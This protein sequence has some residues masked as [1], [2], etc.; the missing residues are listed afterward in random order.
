M[1]VFDLV[2]YQPPANLEVALMK[3]SAAERTLVQECMKVGGLGNLRMLSVTPNE[4]GFLQRLRTL[5]FLF[6]LLAASTA[7]RKGITS[8]S[9]TMASLHSASRF[10]PL[11]TKAVAMS[12]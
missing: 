10:P 4:T 3:L 9:T 11:G 7:T 1:C 5:N 6:N 2:H 8:V 12:K